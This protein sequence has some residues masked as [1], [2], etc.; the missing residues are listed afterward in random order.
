[1]VIPNQ[2]KFFPFF[3]L[4]LLVITPG[5]VV[6]ILAGRFKWK[7][8]VF[9]KQLSSG[10]LLVTGELQFLLEKHDTPICFA[11]DFVQVCYWKVINTLNSLFHFFLSIINIFPNNKLQ[12]KKVFPQERKDDQ[13]SVDALLIMSIEAVPDLKT[14]LAARFSLG[15]GMKP[16]ELVF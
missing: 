1:M 11:T 3:L 7:R 8:V 13:K 5:T 6:I 14:Y 4:F 9:L 12:D 10:L 2:V 15:S 16:Y